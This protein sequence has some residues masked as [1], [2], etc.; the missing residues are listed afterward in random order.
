M[1][2]SGTDISDWQDRAQNGLGLLTAG[3]DRPEDL[4]LETL[5]Y[6]PM[7]LAPLVKE[8]DTSV[9]ADLGHHFKYGHSPARTFETFGDRISIVH[10][11]G[12]DFSFT[13][14]KDHLGLDVLPDDVFDRTADLLASFCGTLSIE[15][16]GR[17]PLRRSVKRLGQRFELGSAL[18][19]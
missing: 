12:A 19:V 11:H 15:V 8:Y 14:A 2:K 1:E 3:L 18:G 4:S 13:P 6:D 17:E 5:W 10:F 16:F 7:V 9:C